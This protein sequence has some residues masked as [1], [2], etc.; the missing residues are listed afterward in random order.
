MPG[1]SVKKPLLLFFLLSYA[2]TWGI[3]IPIAIFYF[4]PLS[5]VSIASIPLPILL[6]TFIAL[7]GPTFA[8]LIMAVTEGG[9]S[10]IRKLLSRWKIWRVGIRWYLVIPF[11]LAGIQLAAVF[12]YVG[13]SAIPLKANWGLWYMFFPYF[14][15]SALLGGPLAEETGWRGYALPRML[16]SQDAFKSGLVLG[17]LWAGWHLP[18]LFIPALGVIPAPLNPLTFLVFFLWVIPASVMMVWLFTNTRGSVLLAFLFHSVHNAVIPTVMLSIF[19]FENL[20]NAEVWVLC[21]VTAL[22]WVVVTFLVVIFKPAYLSRKFKDD[23]DFRASIHS[24]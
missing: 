3:G 1:I 8:A 4:L 21:L 22:E 24:G 6:L 7:F 14:L 5:S 13:I 11:V 9:T 20:P 17:I 19:G 16:N 12:L 10:G 15:T 23:S 2:I 18:F